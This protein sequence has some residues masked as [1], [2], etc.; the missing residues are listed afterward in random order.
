MREEEYKDVIGYEG[1]YQVSNKGNVK[2]LERT[3]W[4]GRGYYKT[5]E[6]ILKSFDDGHGYLQ[7]ILWKGGKS[8]TCKVHRLV[9]EAFL[10]NTDNLPE[11]NH[12][13]ED[14]TNNNVQNLEWC[15]RK[16]N[17]N[18]GTRTEKTSKPVIGI[19]KTS[20]LIVEF[21]SIME[22]ER[23]LGINNGHIVKCCKGKIKSIGGFY[24]MYAEGE[25]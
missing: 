21:S 7:V 15:T 19:N 10:E 4:N 12:I 17:I 24:W 25:D 8:K 11:V 20:G 6:R 9:A 16:Y 22:A 3:V 1:L 13:D 2:S 23:V 18:Y 5:T 14:K